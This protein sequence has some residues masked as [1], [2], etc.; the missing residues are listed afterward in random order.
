MDIMKNTSQIIIEERQ[1]RKNLLDF[2]SI[3]SV[4]ELENRTI[5]L[6]LLKMSGFGIV[7]LSGKV[8]GTVASKNRGG[9]YLRTW[10]KPVNPRTMA[11]TFQ[12]DQLASLA[13]GF[14][15]LG[16]TTIKA[17]NAAA[18]NFPMK[19]RL[20]STI[21]P[22]GLDLYVALNVNLISIGVAQI[23]V[24]PVPQDVLGFNTLSATG[25]ASVLSV[26]FSGTPSPATS[27]ALI[28]ATPG[29]S[30]GKSFVKSEYRLIGHMP[31]STAS[32]FPITSLYTAK[33]GAYI[34][35]TKIFINLRPVNIV[36]GQQQIGLFTSVIPAS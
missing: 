36:S 3:S 13:A 26:V 9:A 4:V 6:A 16:A 35:L 30:S 2:E 32:P 23:T 11:Q 7:A 8:G 15:G 28:F 33:F 34:P 1:E 18:Y 22:S 27:A 31:I 12:R 20:G 14:R 10:V 19:N 17:W 5:C 21:I 24:P 29:L 25:V